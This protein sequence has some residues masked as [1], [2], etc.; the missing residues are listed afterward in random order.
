MTAWLV[1]VLVGLGTYG[2]RALTFGV[3]GERGRPDW[4]HRPRS[5]V[6]AAAIGSLVGGMLLTGHGRIEVAG[7][8]E[9]A[10]AAAAFVAVRRTG[11]VVH[12]LDAGFPVLW[13]LS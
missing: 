6:G 13:L 8:A 2:F 12:A 3:V 11:N 5:C 10:T 4:T 7:L 9:V 1:V